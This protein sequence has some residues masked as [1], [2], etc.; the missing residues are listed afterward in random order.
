VTR[1][2]IFAL[3]SVLALQLINP[4]LQFPRGRVY[5]E[6]NGVSRGLLQIPKDTGWTD[7]DPSAPL[8]NEALR[9]VHCPPKCLN[10]GNTGIQEELPPPGPNVISISTVAPPASEATFTTQSASAPPPTTNPRLQA[11]SCVP[12]VGIYLPIGPASMPVLARFR[13]LNSFPY[14][15]QFGPNHPDAGTNAMTG[16]YACLYCSSGTV[17]FPDTNFPWGL[18]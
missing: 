3:C 17:P 1:A 5:N 18:S 4:I 7:K 2:A 16:L 10:C 8:I 9:L 13:L 14:S 11:M 15:S 12:I 6:R